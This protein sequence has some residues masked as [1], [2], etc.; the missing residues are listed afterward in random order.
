MR[1]PLSW[2]REYVDVVVPTDELAERLTLAGLEVAAVQ[3]IGVPGSALPW[4]PE[5]ILVGRVTAVERHPNA[6]RLVLATVEY[7][8]G[9][10]K[11]VVTG[12]PNLRVGEAGQAVAFALEGARLVDAYAATSQVA[13]LTGRKVRGIYSDAMI[14]SEKELGLSDDHEGVLLLDEAAPVGTPLAAYLGDEVLDIEITP[15]MARCLSLIGVAREVAALTGG[16]VRLPQPRLQAEGEPVAARVQV[17]IADPALAARYAATLIE[18]V[19][20]RPSPEWMRRRL[21]LCGV[22]P[23]SNIVDVTNYV[24]LEW[25]QPLHAFDYDALARRARGGRPT[26]TVRPAK[27]GEVLVTLDG[28]RRTL[29]PERLV[30]AD[31]AGPVAVAGVMGGAETEVTSTTTRILLEAANF[32]LIS[33]RKTTQA[34]K[35]PSEASGR[36]GRGVSPALAVPA[37]LRAT[38]L[39]QALGGGR[40]APGVA[41]CYPR[42]HVPPVIRL[43]M[44][45]VRRVLGVAPEREAVQALLGALDF[46]CEA[47]GPDA[48]RVTAPDYRLDIG[49]GLVGVADLLEEIARLTGYDRMPGTE[50]ADTL[51]PQRNNL[52]VELEDR[53]KDLLVTAGLQEIL[54]YRLTTPEREAALTPGGAE[55]PA[56]VRLANPISAE[57]TV[58]RRTLLPGIL[59]AMAL[60]ARVR[61]RLWLFEVGPVFLPAGA[62]LPQ[63]PRRLA[64]GLRGPLA[65]PS[66][67]APEPPASDFYALKG[68]LEA[69]LAG[70][71]LPAA[72]F[73]P[74]AHPTF[75]PGRAA[76]L[77]LGEACVGVLGEVLADVQAAFDI[78]GGS[79]CVAELDLEAMLGAVPRS[80][81]LAAVPRFPP[82]LQDLAVVVD[83][84]VSAAAVLEAVRAAGGPLLADVRLFDLYRG[85]P[86]PAGQKSLALSLLF[87]APDRTLTDVEVEA[88]KGRVLAALAERLQARLRA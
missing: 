76:E 83:E 46:R 88:A 70:L 55:P 24:M 75:A 80:F 14:L 9:R 11:Q 86:V 85:A 71:H 54:T 77:W 78:P 82:A 73:Q 57:R 47:V 12:A 64:L 50:M 22:R 52:T 13:T 15:N 29:D 23:I 61:D 69:L 16:A 74:A 32:T 84:A 30:I 38:A 1:I 72:R 40:V 67:L 49:E 41:D 2:L 27:P 20:V 6:D 18:G 62:G 5:R 53:V 34:L 44:A 19:S 26:I 39:M 31:S 42:P 81:R 66:W 17:E 56:Y 37:A 36:F 10:T 33:I 4:D 58:M 7:G 43:S 28:E 65:P 35:L 59:T 63:E 87:Q 8:S 45:D 68:V 25:G 3:R 51:P 60:N 21:R 48:L 79:P